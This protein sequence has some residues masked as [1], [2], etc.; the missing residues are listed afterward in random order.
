MGAIA[1]VALVFS[2]CAFVFASYCLIE[3]KAMQRSTH[4]FVMMDPKSQKFSKGNFGASMES[5]LDKK[6]DEIYDNII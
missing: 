4:Q 5:G 3:I 1:I 2:V 6:M